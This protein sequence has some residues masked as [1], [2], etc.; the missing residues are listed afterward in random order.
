MP[1][2]KLYNYALLY[3]LTSKAVFAEPKPT[4]TSLCY[5]ADF[6]FH[7]L[8]RLLPAYAYTVAGVMLLTSV[9]YQ[10]MIPLMDPLVQCAAKYWQNLLFVSSLFGSPCLG[11][12]WYFIG[13]ISE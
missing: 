2:K 4:W 8:M 11:Y 7:R 13:F 6:Y 5:W 12:T 1:R 9:H 10:P 3:K